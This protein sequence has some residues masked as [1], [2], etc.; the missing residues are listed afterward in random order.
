M[1]DVVLRHVLEQ[2]VELA[3]NLQKQCKCSTANRWLVNPVII[4]RLFQNINTK[5]NLVGSNSHSPIWFLTLK[6]T[7]SILETTRI[8]LYA[9]INSNLIFGSI[10]NLQHN[11]E[12][13]FSFYEI[14]QYLTSTVCI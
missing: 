14:N 12:V 9:L 8:S 7:I 6:S 2:P 11:L 4:I 3:Y 13:Y 1:T 10:K 5:I